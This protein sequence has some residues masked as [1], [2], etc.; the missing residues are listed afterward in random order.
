MWALGWAAKPLSKQFMPVAIKPSVA[1]RQRKVFRNGQETQSDNPIRKRNLNVFL[2]LNHYKFGPF[3]ALWAKVL[4]NLLCQ[5]GHTKFLVVQR[6]GDKSETWN[7]SQ[8]PTSYHLT[9]RS[10]KSPLLRSYPPSN[11][12]DRKQ[13]LVRARGSKS[14][15]A[16]VFDQTRCSRTLAYGSCL[17]NRELVKTEA[18]KK[19]VF[20]QTVLLK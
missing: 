2:C 13:K 10:M 15:N 12:S 18:F 9:L 4:L 1:E 6:V 3:K 7:D 8:A 17:N 11:N 5:T 16:E 14:P 20:K 19:G